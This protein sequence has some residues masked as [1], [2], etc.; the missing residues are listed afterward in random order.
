MTHFRCLGSIRKKKGHYCFNLQNICNAILHPQQIYSS[1]GIPS[2][3]IIRLKKFKHMMIYSSSFL[4]CCPCWE[5]ASFLYS[6]ILVPLLLT[7][8]RSLL[9]S[10]SSQMTSLWSTNFHFCLVGQVGKRLSNFFSEV[11]MYNFLRTT[12]KTNCLIQTGVCI[13]SSCS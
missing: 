8:D 12:E 11:L 3:V 6:S 9:S 1:P 10:T 4:T 13:V 5:T 2:Q 7:C